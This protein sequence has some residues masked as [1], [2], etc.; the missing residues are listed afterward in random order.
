MSGAATSG[1]GYLRRLAALDPRGSLITPADLRVLLLTGQ[2]SFRSARLAD[3]QVEFLRT[4]SPCAGAAVEAGFPFHADLLAD[5]REPF[6]LV[7]ASARNARQVVWSVTSRRYRQVVEHTLQQALD[8]T[9]ERLIVVTGS[10]GLQLL[11][12][13]WTPLALPPRLRVQ[14]VALGPACFAPLRLAPAE[15]TVIAGARDPWS[16]LFYGGRTDVRVA[17]GHLDYWTS[18]EVR[19][20]VAAILR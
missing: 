20:R 5:E 2:S 11:N 17:C 10:C 8:A 15:V 12:R 1:R 3:E 16:R 9:R 4:V 18:P 7:A 6:A 19:A 13:A 14:V